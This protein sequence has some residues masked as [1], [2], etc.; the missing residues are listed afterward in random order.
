MSPDTSASDPSGTQVVSRTEVLT[1]E[2]AKALAGLL[3]IDPPDPPGDLP[4]LWHWV[5]L[6]ERR[7]QRDLGPDGHPATGIPA[8]PV[9]GRLRM[10]A[11]G[12]VVLHAALHLHEPATRKTR[13]VRTVDKQ[14]R[15]GPMTFA[16]VR[17]EIEQGGRTVVT[18]E[19]DI[20]YRAGGSSLPVPSTSGDAPGAR[21]TAIG[22]LEMAVDP[23]VLFRF[24]ALMYNSH[25]IHY[26]TEY[27]GREGYPGLVVHGPLQALLMGECLRRS[28][29]PLVGRR[30]AYRLL[31]PIFGAQRLR[32]TAHQ[33]TDGL[34]AHVWDARGL[35]S[36]TA[37]LQ[38][39]DPSALSD[40][41][42]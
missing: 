30:F 16:T 32:I 12:R 26:D 8:P 20:V 28:G 35:R 38:P 13:L 2:A 17:N 10:F 33:D 40:G 23:V 24:S 42:S 21:R 11:G 41:A 34:T 31:T 22:S 29:A 36:A 4:P 7:P 15:S 37:T 14:G 25:R 39:L 3:D 9:P 5:Y 18:D 19:Q 1:P 6:L 27:A